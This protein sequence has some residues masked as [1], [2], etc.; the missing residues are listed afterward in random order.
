MFLFCF[1]GRRNIKILGTFAYSANVQVFF[2]Y[3]LKCAVSFCI[4]GE[5]AQLH[6]TYSSIERGSNSTQRLICNSMYS[7]VHRVSFCIFCE[8]SQFHSVYSV[9]SHSNTTSKN[10]TNGYNWIHD[11]RDKYLIHSSFKEIVS[12]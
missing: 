4:F 6:T 9:A 7:A 2:A 1:Q 5:W 3:V 11:N 12:A 8:C 10:N